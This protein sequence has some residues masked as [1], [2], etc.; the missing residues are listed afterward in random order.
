MKCGLRLEVEKR[1]IPASSDPLGLYQCTYSIGIHQMTCVPDDPAHPP[2]ASSEFVSGT[3]KS[4]NCPNCQN[5]PDRTDVPF[6]GPLPATQYS[7]GPQ[8]GLSRRDLTPTDPTQMGKRNGMQLHGC[9]N[10]ATC[11]NGCIGATSNAIRDQLNRILGLEE[12][13]NTL[14]VV[15]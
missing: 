3:N 2:F 10:S 14:L 6:L 11:S 9:T 7:I 15:P 5:N 8:H 4:A 13:H 1:G 12:G